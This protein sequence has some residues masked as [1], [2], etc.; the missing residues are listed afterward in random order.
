MVYRLA[1]FIV[2][3]SLVALSDSHLAK[4]PY[5]V[6]PDWPQLPVG[7]NFA[8]TAG[9][10]VDAKEN[11]Y[12]FHRGEEPIFVIDKSG[13]FLRSMG[14]GIYK[15][16]HGITRGPTEFTSTRTATCGRPMTPAT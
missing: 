15:R 11:V 8:E 10:A 7:R 4:L 3:V 16:P 5:E 14:K 2:C 9:V 6:D 1:A 13:K 12:V